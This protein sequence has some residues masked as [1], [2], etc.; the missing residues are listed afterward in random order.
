[1]IRFFLFLF[2]LSSG[3]C[4]AKAINYSQLTPQIIE[5]DLANC[6][7][8]SPKLNVTCSDLKQIAERI[9]DLAIQLQVDRQGYGKAI[10][11]AEE[12]L[13][14][15]QELLAKNQGD[16]KIVA[17]IDL[18]QQEINERLAIVKWLESPR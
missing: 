15:Q 9:N 12:K 7:Q 6:P 18:N 5:N 4:F 13:A 10:L 3:T 2:V 1:M 8:K 16:S 17:E 14:L 11:A